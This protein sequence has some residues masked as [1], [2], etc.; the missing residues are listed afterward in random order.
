[1]AEHRTKGCNAPQSPPE[2]FCIQM[3][4]VL[5]LSL[6]NVSAFRW[7]AFSLSLSVMFLHSDGQL[8]LSL[9]LSLGLEGRGDVTLFRQSVG[10]GADS[11]PAKVS[12]VCRCACVRW[13]VRACASALC[14]CR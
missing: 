14:V 13:S 9:S 1:M 8:S 5:S 4:S 2:C 3:G 12:K 10:S 11:C 7:A 6:C